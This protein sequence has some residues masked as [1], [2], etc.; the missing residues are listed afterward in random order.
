MKTMSIWVA[1]ATLFLASMGICSCSMGST[2]S[3][4]M[5][6]SLEF[7]QD[8]LREKPFKAIDV[9]MV[10]SVYYTQNDGDECS[11]RLDYSAI[12]DAEFVQKLKEKIKVVY[13]DG[14]SFGGGIPEAWRCGS[15]YHIYHT[16]KRFF[17]YLALHLHQL[18]FSYHF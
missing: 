2:T 12:K 15:L 18:V 10:A 7:T 1:S 8:D 16:K 4:E 9:D 5:R 6:G 13:R 17:Q 3:S 11:V 14:G